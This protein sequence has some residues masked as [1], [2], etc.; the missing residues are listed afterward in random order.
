M[1]FGTAPYVMADDLENL[2]RVRQTGA[3]EAAVFY[4]ARAV[5]VLSRAAVER[6]ELKPSINAYA[7]LQRLEE[8]GLLADADRYWAHGLRRLGND[9]RHSLRA[10]S[11]IDVEFAVLYLERW[12]DWFFCEFKLGPQL[13]SI[14][15][16]GSSFE[17]DSRSDC[18]SVVSRIDDAHDPDTIL[19]AAES[20]SAKKA[21]ARTP[22]IAAVV[23]ESLLDIGQK[24]RA[25]TVVSRALECHPNE[26]RLQQLH[27]LSM[28]RLKQL[29]AARR[30]LE[31]LQDQNPNDEETIGILG[32]V[33]KRMADAQ[34][35]NRGWL[36]K[37]HKAYLTGWR[38]S[39]RS[40]AYLG[41]NAAST[42][43]LL[44][45]KETCRK[46][47]D[48]VRRILVERRRRITVADTSQPLGSYWNE[49]T[50]AEAEVLL[51][52]WEAADE[53][54]RQ[55]IV[56]FAHSTGSIDVTRDQVLRLADVMGV[57][58]RLRV[59]A[60]FEAPGITPTGP[61]P[62]TRK[63]GRARGQSG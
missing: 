55:A 38:R 29:E 43:L 20:P 10:V 30:L 7:N 45:E 44:G 18:R 21:V 41:I 13:A 28:S 60:L 1:Q 47:A 32:G 35:E 34:D 25:E 49:A 61:P 56:H 19:A 57:D 8:F 15:G 22:T 26:L 58:A 27:A 54:I 51:E 52:N 59:P 14:T 16:D 46:L 11:A 3:V 17:L 31:K 62:S 24:K 39:Q 4:C 12:L 48:D 36:R 53:T 5:D 50:L 9:V 37:S 6:M 40:N 33:Y 63:H 2:H 42:A 23:V